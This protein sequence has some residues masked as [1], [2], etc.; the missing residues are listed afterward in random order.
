MI[1]RS[2]DSFI[3]RS[4]HLPVQM[5]QRLLAAENLYAEALEI[6]QG[7]LLLQEALLIASPRLH[8]AIQK[9][10]DQK[11]QASLLKYL[12]RM[13]SRATPFGLFASVGLGRFSNYSS[14]VP[15]VE[16]FRRKI[17][18]DSQ[19]IDLLPIHSDPE[20]WRQLRVQVNPQILQRTG[21]VMLAFKKN[22]TSVQK[23]SALDA[24][25]SLAH[26][27]ISYVQL[28]ETLANQFPDFPRERVRNYLSDL[29][30][31]KF[32]LPETT[33]VVYAADSLLELLRILTPLDKMSHLVRPLNALHQLFLGYADQPHLLEKIC[34]EMESIKEAESYVKV[35]AICSTSHSELSFKV[36]E[37][38]EEA[39]YLLWRLSLQSS[40]NRE[41]SALF[42][43]F[44]ERHGTTRLIPFHEVIG[45]SLFYEILSAKSLE[46]PQDSLFQSLIFTHNP[47]GIRE[48]SLDQVIPTLPEPS[49]EELQRA[50][51]S[52]DLCFEIAASSSTALDQGDFRLLLLG[53]SAQA[54]AI[55]GRFIKFFDPELSAPLRE[56]ISRESSL[57]SPAVFVE[58][59]F[60]PENLKVQSV[61]ARNVLRFQQ[62]SM[63]YHETTPESIE[64][65]DLYIGATT[66]FLYLFSKKLQKEVRIH[67]SNM[68]NP[69]LAPIG[70]R[71]L[72]EISKQRSSEFSTDY[73]RIFRFGAYI[74]RVRYKNIILSPAVWTFDF[75]SLALSP[76]A[77]KAKIQKALLDQF[78]R[79]QIP[80]EVYLSSYDNRLLLH[81]KRPEYFSILLKS[82]LNER[83]VTL[84]ENVILAQERIVRRHE[85][86]YVSEFVFSFVKQQ[87]KI[88]SVFSIPRVEEIPLEKRLFAPGSE[89][90]ALKIYLPKEETEGFIE[91]TLT[92]FFTQLSIRNWFYIRY[93]DERFHIRLR[94]RATNSSLFPQVSQFFGNLLTKKIIEDLLLFPYEREVERYGGLEGI[95][96]AEEFFCKDS[97]ASILLFPHLRSLF[98]SYA[99]AAFGIMQI[100]HSFDQLPPVTEESMH[101]LKGSRAFEQKFLSYA[102]R[103]FFGAPDE[104][105]DGLFRVIACS[106]H[107]KA[108]SL[109][110][111]ADKIGRPE[112]VIASLIHM[113]CNR[114]LGPFREEE[115]KALAIA[116][117]FLAKL[118][119]RAILQPS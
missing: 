117:H 10:P 113:H 83:S 34:L 33:T 73:S 65:E 49:D 56:W 84:T 15:I 38:A 32:L 54:G 8:R 13:F 90:I 30:N 116:C 106:I 53:A 19:W 91:T 77:S 2:A 16:T 47:T 81:W 25:L 71:L 58:A 95:E 52:F 89:W 78:S 3:I 72:L 114:L 107:I 1:Y 11:V 9:F 94:L 88:A 100:L 93:K 29:C 99:V 27:P 35:D 82:F 104:E 111:Y 80:D 20:I 42:Q 112:Q 24:V 115:M 67:L 96:L 69:E 4:A 62:L 22:Y 63:D 45:E 17:Q 26:Q 7:S 92:P 37:S 97:E 101:L 64:L 44:L 75:N 5:A 39:A 119:K 70:L 55:F 61:S 98:P 43:A 102:K 60:L 86:T 21:R 50:P 109:Q 110:R 57:S 23:T 6:Y 76:D 66:D 48:I 14:L 28:E 40:K 68:I 108:D 41:K 118:K 36:K 105:S 79:Y 12:L 31:K 74:P 85:E 46:G 87:S 18:V 59:S 51:S 103:L